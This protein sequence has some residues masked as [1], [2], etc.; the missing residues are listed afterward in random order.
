[1]AR[2]FAAGTAALA[3]ALSVLG[4]C[5]VFESTTVSCPTVGVLDHAGHLTRFK[6]DGQRDLTDVEFQAHVGS[7]E[8]ECSF[9]GDTRTGS[10]DLDILFRA[11]RGPAGAAG[12]HNFDYFVAVVDPEG[13][14]E[15][16]KAF[17]V[18]VAFEG[19]RTEVTRAEPLVLDIPIKE[20]TSLASYRVYVGMQLTKEQFDSNLGGGR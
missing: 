16:R 3:V 20:N 15:A 5:S 13:G 12:T 9:D 7:L 1:M 10:I 14:V 11:Q 18:Q 17:S 19:S 2:G 8:A 4:G 6:S